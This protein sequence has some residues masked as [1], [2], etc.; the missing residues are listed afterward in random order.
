VY[1]MAGVSANFFLGQKITTISTHANS[2]DR[3]SVTGNPGFSTFNLAM[4]AGC[5]IKYP[6]SKKANIKIEPVYRRSLTPI[7]DAPVKSYLYSAGINFGIF[8]EL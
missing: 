4:I 3:T 8:Y 5:G 6:L 7:M 2:N 1:V